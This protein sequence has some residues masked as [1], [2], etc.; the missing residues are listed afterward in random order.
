MITDFEGIMMKA[1]IPGN[2]AVL[3]ILGKTGGHSRSPIPD[4][5]TEE[6]EYYKQEI[7]NLAA[8]EEKLSSE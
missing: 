7:K 4:A 1:F 5:T 6:I 2:R 3:D 8:E